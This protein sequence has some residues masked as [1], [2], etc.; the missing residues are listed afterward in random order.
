MV[1]VKH[2]KEL[3]IHFFSGVASSDQSSGKSWVNSGPSSSSSKPNFLSQRS[4][5][6]G[7]EFPS[8]ESAA[9]QE[10]LKGLQQQQ[11]HQHQQQQQNHS[12]QNSSQPQPDS[13]A[14][15]AL[16]RNKQ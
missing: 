12:H 3:W 5:L 9:E 16:L 7:Q 1:L 13:G 8:L 6:F 4:P 11:Q 14:G 10:K 15:N 2:L